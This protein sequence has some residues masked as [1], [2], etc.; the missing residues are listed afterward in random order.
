VLKP[1]DR[2]LTEEE[3]DR[4]AGVSRLDDRARKGNAE[5]SA[6]RHLSECQDCRHQLDQRINADSKLNMLRASSSEARGELCPNNEVWMNVAAGLANEDLSRRMLD[7]AAHCDHCGPLF[8]DL[9]NEFA[10]SVSP[11]EM[12]I[13]A[14]LSSNSPDWQSRMAARLSASTGARKQSFRFLIRYRSWK[15]LAFGCTSAALAAVM[16]W[17]F[18]PRPERRVERLLA[19]AY[20]E[21]RTI[22]MRVPNARYAPVRVERG[23]TRTMPAELHEAMAIVMRELTEHPEDA[24]LLDE[25]GRAQILAGDYQGALQSLEHARRL[26]PESS[27]ILIDLATAYFQLVESGGPK[28][29]YGT[30]LDLLGQVLAK[31][32][33][34]AVAL[35]NRA[36]AN[37]RLP[38]NE[39]QAIDDWQH[40]LAVDPNGDWT[41]EARQRL[42]QLQHKKPLNPVSLIRGQ[43]V[44][45]VDGSPARSASQMDPQD[46]E[47]LDV[48]I[49]ESLPIW[50]DTPSRSEVFESQNHSIGDLAEKLLRDH[51]DRWLLDIMHSHRSPRF[52]R[53]IRELSIAAQRDASGD[54]TDAIAHAALAERS[55]EAVGSVAGYIRA[56]LER[57]YA[58]QRALQVN[59][60]M[61]TA[62][63][64]ETRLR[65]HGYRWAET[66][67][68]LEESACEN[69]LGNLGFEEPV[70]K[71]ALNMARSHSYGV[72]YLRGL[73]FAA[74][75]E[76]AKGDLNK[77]WEHDLEG[78]H[79]YSAGGYPA[80][81]AYQFY[82]DMALTAEAAHRWYLAVG[83]WRAVIALAADSGNLALEAQSTYQLAS[84][85][86]LIGDTQQATRHFW[87]SRELYSELPKSDAV[88]AY[89]LNGDISLASLEARA[90]RIADAFERLDRVLPDL[91]LVS[92]YEIPLRYYQTLGQLYLLR[93]E[94]H[95]ANRALTTAVAIAERGLT[96]L[97]TNSDKITWERDTGDAYRLLVELKLRFENDPE[98]ALALWEWYQA[99]RLRPQRQADSPLNLDEIQG[100]SINSKVE[101]ARRLL[102]L[103]RKTDLL[104]YARLSTGYAGWIV[105]QG[106]TRGAFLSTKLVDLENLGETFI[107]ECAN[108]SSNQSR[109]NS[110]GNQ[111]FRMMLSPFA[112]QLDFRGELAIEADGVLNR[113]PLE[114]LSDDSGQFLGDRYS[115]ITFPGVV[116]EA[117]FREPLRLTGLERA[118]VVGDPSSSPDLAGKYP[119][120][121]DARLEAAAIAGQFKNSVL[122]TGT[123]ATLHRVKQY[124]RGAELFHFAGHSFSTGG[125]A[126]LLLAVAETRRADGESTILYASSL[127]GIALHKCRLVVLSACSISNSSLTEN[128]DPETLVEAFQQAGVP[129]VLASR[130]NVDSA[131]T[132]AFMKEFYSHLLRGNSAAVASRQAALAVRRNQQTSHPYYWAAFAT[133]GVAD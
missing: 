71:R 38:A 101:E 112:G 111:L 14:G 27:T 99:A 90:G 1:S 102:G 11:E 127:D 52:S 74:G 103:K 41:G 21:Q 16:I 97:R 68:L 55:F 118:L 40:F 54:S 25:K 79:V 126:G 10:D 2:H 132:A 49:R 100:E 114:A 113:I 43:T 117:H 105:K 33:N 35:Y 86:S 47:S 80:L 70:L 15:W 9:V 72:L 61:V 84:L 76:T 65:G 32:P 122:L 60:C 109:L 50:V 81:R 36:I 123:D 106:R 129:D 85:E 8:H 64:L 59:E 78:L 20:T 6:A 125:G 131:S 75:L 96:S 57:I 58:L 37:E 23:G 94:T 19:E 22:T 42:E 63:G 124:L 44:P 108:A 107:E 69:M 12:Q 98:G 51:G 73:G 29:H 56:R 45:L 119:N 110:H 53:A 4:L 3:L 26:A 24:K 34:D 30:T 13:V 133:F 82:S 128:T 18:L 88:R 87:H 31:N 5:E 95:L 91:H 104:V 39:Q 116:N 93:K 7:H 130:W 77:A 66:Q 48:A 83:L 62:K 46:E 67:L 115:L 28:I 89:L 92:D 17:I 120:L 121:P